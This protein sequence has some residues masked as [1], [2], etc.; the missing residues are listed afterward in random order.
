LDKRFSSE[1]GNPADL[2]KSK[3][4]ERKRRIEFRTSAARISTTGVAAM[5]A[6]ETRAAPRRIAKLLRDNV[7][8][9]PDLSLAR[10]LG[11]AVQPGTIYVPLLPKSKR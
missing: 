8:L 9:H 6:A 5:T 11:D 7:Y 1:D 4:H 10:S 3:Q 2:V